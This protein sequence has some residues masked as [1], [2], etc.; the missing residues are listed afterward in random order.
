MSLTKE[1]IINLTRYFGSET[2]YREEDSIVVDDWIEFLERHCL[3]PRQEH[4]LEI[5]LGDKEYSFRWIPYVTLELYNTI[6]EKVFIGIAPRRQEG[7]AN[8]RVQAFEPVFNRHSV[9]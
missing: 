1:E 6:Y 2:R 9:K 7:S 4:E 8:V 5:K 3:N